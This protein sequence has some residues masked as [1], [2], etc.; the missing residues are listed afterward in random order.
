MKSSF[1]YLKYCLLPAYVFGEFRASSKETLHVTAS[2]RDEFRKGERAI[3]SAELDR[4]RIPTVSGFEENGMCELHRTSV[5]VEKEI[6]QVNS[7][8]RSQHEYIGN[9]C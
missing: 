4:G 9:V 1:V 8:C 5:D 7:P 6:R 2:G 3:V